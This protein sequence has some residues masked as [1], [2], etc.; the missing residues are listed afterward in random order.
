MVT[1]IC[2]RGSTLARLAMVLVWQS[3]G[4]PS[5]KFLH[6]GLVECFF[7]QHISIISFLKIPN[8]HIFQF[9]LENSHFSKF[10]K[11][12]KYHQSG[13]RIMFS[14]F[15]HTHVDLQYSLDKVFFALFARSS[16]TLITRQNFALFYHFVRAQVCPA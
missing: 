2:V 3:C 1:C 7:I 12:L 6:G 8:F 10:P 15:Y 4:K 14:I 16:K 11:I 13:R 5:T 9:F